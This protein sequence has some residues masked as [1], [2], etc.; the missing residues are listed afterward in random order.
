M[1]FSWG[2]TFCGTDFQ[3]EVPPF[4]EEFFKAQALYFPEE[5]EEFIQ[6]HGL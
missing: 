1:G 2:N 4:Q 3:A 5:C 6:M